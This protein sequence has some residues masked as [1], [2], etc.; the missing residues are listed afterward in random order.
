MFASRKSLFDR[1]HSSSPLLFSFLLVLGYISTIPILNFLSSPTG[2][3]SQVL[4]PLLSIALHCVSNG[5]L[6]MER[7]PDK[8]VALLTLFYAS[9]VFILSA[10]VSV[11]GQLLGTEEGYKNKEPRIVKRT[12]PS[13][14]PHRM[15]A[16]HEAL[17]ETFP[18]FAISAAL[19]FSAFTGSSTLS[20]PSVSTSLNAL[21]LH[22]FLKLFVY[23]PAY[24]FDFDLVRSNAH[25]HA[26]VVAM[27][28]I[29]CIVVG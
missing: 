19:L 13:G 9:A 15:I 6:S 22:V 28:S 10:I 24:L 16:T 1:P 26:S 3:V 20:A 7:N 27:L 12:I 18:V 29:W 25:M 5:T 2:L 21:V 4:T 8:A 11:S 14:F 17:C 23:T